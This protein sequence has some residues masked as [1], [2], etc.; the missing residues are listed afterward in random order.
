MGARLG[1][2]AAH[3]HRAPLPRTVP[4]G[5]IER[6]PAVVCRADLDPVDPFLDGDLGCCCCKETRGRGRAQLDLTVRRQRHLYV[7]LPP[8]S[9]L[10]G[11]GQR[12]QV[13]TQLASSFEGPGILRSKAPVQALGGE[14]RRPAV[15]SVDRISALLDIQGVEETHD[16]VRGVAADIETDEIT[17]RGH[18]TS[19]AK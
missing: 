17:G 5:V 6:P 11:T 12:P 19:V 1:P 13:P 16:K 2:V 10:L 9:R 18:V 3:L 7:D 4:R 15:E 8:P 14:P